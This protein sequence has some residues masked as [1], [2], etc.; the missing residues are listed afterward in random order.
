[1][2]SESPTFTQGHAGKP[3]TSSAKKITAESQSRNSFAKILFAGVILCVITIG[4]LIA[5]FTKPEVASNLLI[6]VS[7]GIGYLLAG[8]ES[9]QRDE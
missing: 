5:L 9:S 6:V 1:M 8:K 4:W 7:G 3:Q 2:A